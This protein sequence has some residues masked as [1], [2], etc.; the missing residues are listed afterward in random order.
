MHDRWSSRRG[1]E[2]P[3]S[4]VAVSAESEVARF[5]T[6][7]N[8][9]AAA[10][11]FLATAQAFSRIFTTQRFDGTQRRT[12]Y[13]G[14]RKCAEG[15]RIRIWSRVSKPQP[16]PTTQPCG[17]MKL[18]FFSSHQRCR[19]D[20]AVLPDRYISLLYSTFRWASSIQRVLNRY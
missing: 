10:L 1:P 14:G 6:H 15:R 18:T 12:S 9:E 17:R 20:L 16:R 19:R 11:S 3:S 5:S 13:L 2:H 8:S 4:A 7:S